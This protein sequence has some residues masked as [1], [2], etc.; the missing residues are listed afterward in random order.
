[1]PHSSFKLIPGVDTTKTPA[2]NEAAISQ[3]QLIRFIPD[4]TLGGII[5]KLGGW[6]KYVQTSLGSICRCLWAWEDTNSN[7][8]LAAGCEGQAAGAGG[9]LQVIQSGNSTDITPQEINYNVTPNFSTTSGSNQITVTI[10]GASIDSLDAIYIRTQVA[11][12]GLIL[13]GLYQCYPA[14]SVDTCYIYATNVLGDPAY[15]TSTVTNGGVVP[16]FTATASLAS[17]NVNLPNHGYSIGETFPIL[18]ATTLN[19]LIL[20]GNYI[21][22]TVVD[23]DNFTIAAFNV[24]SPVSVT[25]ASGTGTTAT[26]TFT[27]LVKFT[28]GDLINV[29]SVNPS[30]YNGTGLTVSA[31]SYGTVSYANTTT[32]A[33]VS[34][35]YIYGSY[36]EYE[37]SGNANIVQYNGIPQATNP[38]GYG[39]GP[40]GVG[41]YGTGSSISPVP[42]QYINAV[43][44]TLDNWGSILVAN[45]YGDGIFIWDPASGV[46]N[47]TIIPQ[48]PPVN[49]GMFVA[50][51]QRQ[52]IAWGSTDTGIVDPLFIRWCD[53]ND[54]NQWTP[55]LT[56]QAGSFRIP[57]GSRI[58]QCI[59]GPQQ[60][61]IWTD[62]GLWAMQYVGPTYVYSFN[63]L[64]NGCG[65]IGRKA[66]GSM[67]GVV[68]WM[69]QSQFYRLD[70]SG[71][72]PIRCPVWDVVFQELDRVDK[73]KIRFAANSRFGEVSWYF[74]TQPGGDI[75]TYVKYNIYLD[76]WDYGTLS[77]TAWINESV[78]GPPIGAS[79]NFYLYQHETGYN[80]D[81]QPMNSYF[82]TGYF[83]LTEAEFKMFVDQI[84]PDMKW[85]YYGN[86]N[87]GANV[88]FTFYVAD[89]PTQTP[90]AYGPFTMT[91]AINYITPRFRGRLVSIK[92]ESNDIDTWWRLGN[93]RYRVSQDGKY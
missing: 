19:N 54:Y 81:D 15:A 52:I 1:M 60:G 35:G 16:Y 38:K 50:M 34:G 24:A 91:Q 85:G 11:V 5:Q 53:V 59:Q 10:T 84:W 44:W 65:L 25:G 48:A 49:Y 63:E 2:L 75:T 31:S 40:Y 23:A 43:D 90:T 8:Y 6:T 28:S 71:P 79:S 73:D 77:R 72:E 42:G 89:Y 88:L 27:S 69:G 80:A 18:I 9:A 47:A 36:S 41:G 76:Q 4:R 87:Q 83:V 30:G 33:Y 64:G 78:L 12:G 57:K 21:V 55:R 26:L 20:Y 70:A 67:N 58:V 39:Q 7:S 92:V 66:A 61:L 14:G 32:A 46:G 86:S 82:Q 51:P 37:N 93:I 29:D 45:P 13:Y 3:S 17:V 68:Y 56:N 74:P 62:L 22:N